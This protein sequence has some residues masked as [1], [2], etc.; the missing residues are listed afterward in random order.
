MFCQIILIFPIF[1]HDISSE[2]SIKPKLQTPIHKGMGDRAE[3]K[4]SIL[5]WKTLSI[6]QNTNSQRYVR[7][8]YRN[9]WKAVSSII[10]R[11]WVTHVNWRVNCWGRRDNNE[12]STH[13]PQLTSCREESKQSY[14]FQQ[15][16]FQSICSSFSSKSRKLR[17]LG[18]QHENIATFVRKR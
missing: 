9:A 4:D 13:C 6:K 14:I 12:S 3:E 16:S 11:S 15:C 5:L 1:R 18:T 2:T 8:V 10:W 17:N 7:Q